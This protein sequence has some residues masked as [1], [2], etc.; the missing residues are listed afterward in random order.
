[1]CL[2]RSRVGRGRWGVSPRAVPG[3]GPRDHNCFPGHT[4][5]NMSGES[6]HRVA[7]TLSISPAP[8]PDTS[9]REY[10]CR[11]RIR[12]PLPSGRLSDGLERQRRRHGESHIGRLRQYSVL[13]E[14]YMVP[15]EGNVD[16]CIHEIDDHLSPE[17][18]NASAGVSPWSPLCQSCRLYS[19]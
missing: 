13:H 7:T 3:R 1:M 16:Q 15:M 6:E 5:W 12:S 8:E 10:I 11:G 14:L 2:G 18:E 9:P 17:G 19:T 4:L